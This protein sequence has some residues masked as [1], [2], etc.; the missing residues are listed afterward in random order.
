VSG[1]TY[2]ALYGLAGHLRDNQAAAAAAVNAAAAGALVTLP[3]DALGDATILIRPQVER[4][5]IGALHVT[6]TAGVARRERATA[7]RVAPTGGQDSAQVEVR[8]A[9]E[10]PLG[11]GYTTTA[12]DGGAYAP[13]PEGLLTLAGLAWGDLIAR[14]LVSTDGVAAAGAQAVVSSQTAV[15]IH[16]WRDGGSN[17]DA[18]AVVVEVAVVYLQRQAYGGA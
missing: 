1:T 18:L 16:D 8:A 13:D 9:V 15:E 4:L 17:P 7:T 10:V 12:P 2:T 5:P 6:L 3:T 11:L 14:L